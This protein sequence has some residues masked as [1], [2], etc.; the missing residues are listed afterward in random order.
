LTAATRWQH[1]MCYGESGTL[2]GCGM[3]L[4]DAERRDLATP[5]KWSPPPTPAEEPCHL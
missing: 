4:G 2:G 3:P 5:G 1:G